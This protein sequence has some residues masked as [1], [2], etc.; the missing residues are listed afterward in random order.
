MKMVSRLLLTAGE[1]DF[2]V[3]L[4]DTLET[5]STLLDAGAQPPAGIP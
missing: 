2:R 5:W 4:S 3:P 1:R